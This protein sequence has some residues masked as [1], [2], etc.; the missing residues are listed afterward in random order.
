MMVETKC[1]VGEARVRV[2][3]PMAIVYGI[4]VYGICV[5]GICGSGHQ[6]S[7]DVNV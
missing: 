6:Q 5:Y 7:P 3:R 2:V 1:S 4:C